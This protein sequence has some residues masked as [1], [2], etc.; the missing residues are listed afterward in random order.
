VSSLVRG[1]TKGRGARTVPMTEEEVDAL[2]D[3]QIEQGG[4]VS[5]EELV[6]PSDPACHPGEGDRR[7]VDAEQPGL[8]PEAM[9]KFLSS[10]GNL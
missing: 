10:R 6:D 4:S 9:S 7:S 3:E 2:L 1:K 5:P 8:D